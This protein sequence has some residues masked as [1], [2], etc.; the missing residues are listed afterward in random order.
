MNRCQHESNKDEDSEPDLPPVAIDALR[1]SSCRKRA[2]RH[3]TEDESLS[4][5]ASLASEKLVVRNRK[6]KIHS[7]RLYIPFA[8]LILL[9][10]LVTFTSEEL[11]Y[12]VTKSPCRIPAVSSTALCGD[13]LPQARLVDFRTLGKT[14]SSSIGLLIGDS[15]GNSE[16]V[17]KI[18]KTEMAAD[19]LA[20]AVRVSDL[21]SR[22]SLADMLDKFA[23]SAGLVAEELQEFH[24][25]I[26]GTANM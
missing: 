7:S 11:L 21:R 22:D 26:V 1:Q 12:Q 25:Q 6:A 15:F 17:L 20:S 5:M 14:Q 24:A 18:A 10:A 3:T 9:A 19:D 8:F 16:M 23:R 13:A 2:Q 4:S